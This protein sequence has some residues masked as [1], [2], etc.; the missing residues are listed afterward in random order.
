MLALQRIFFWYGFYFIDRNFCSCCSRQTSH[1]AY[2]Q[3]SFI[4]AKNRLPSLKERKQEDIH[5]PD[6]LT[7]NI[8]EPFLLASP[9]GACS[10][11]DNQGSIHVVC[12]VG[13]HRAQERALQQSFSVAAHHHRLCI[14]FITF[15][16]DQFLESKIS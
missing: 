15:Y 11:H 12:E 9:G 16:A 10:W 6:G 1:F 13:R 8:F 2:I 4:K 3:Q 7:E 5:R 14:H